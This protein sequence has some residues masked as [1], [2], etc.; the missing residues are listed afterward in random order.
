MA[1]HFPIAMTELFSETEKACFHKNHMDIIGNTFIRLMA[2]RGLA[3][4]E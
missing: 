3:R 4:S 2:F 1:R